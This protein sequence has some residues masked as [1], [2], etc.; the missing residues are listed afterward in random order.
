MTVL[1]PLPKKKLNYFFFLEFP[2]IAYVIQEEYS[3]IPVLK[4]LVSSAFLYSEILKTEHSVPEV[5]S[6][7]YFRG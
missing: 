3:K 5:Y 4:L 2:T 7:S 1:L 6:F